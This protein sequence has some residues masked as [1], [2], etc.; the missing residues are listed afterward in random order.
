M[1]LK[2]IKQALNAFGKYVIQQSRSN[3]T[4]TKKNVDKKLYDSLHYDLDKV[5]SGYKIILK[6]RIMECFKI[7]GLKG[8]RVE[9]V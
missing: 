2:S 7:E 5:S 9:K 1:E 8:Q 4:K 6:W 3:L